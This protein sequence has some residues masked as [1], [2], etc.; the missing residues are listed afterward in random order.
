MEYIFTL[1]EQEVGIVA[2]A[3]MELPYKVS[4]P[5]LGKLDAQIAAQQ[6][7]PAEEASAEAEEQA[8]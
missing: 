5:L 8:E 1:T 4:A 2:R 7:P 3:L 6:T